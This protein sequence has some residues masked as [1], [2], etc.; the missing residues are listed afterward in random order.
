LPALRF[1]LPIAATSLLGL[2]IIA[3]ALASPAVSFDDAS[4]ESVPEVYNG[5]PVE[6]CAWPTVVAVTGGGLC[7]GTLI[8]PELVVYAAHCG[9]GQK[10]LRFSTSSGSGGFSVVGSCTT[11]PTY[12]GVTDVKEDWAFCRL[13]QPVNIPI[14]PAMHGCEMDLLEPGVE[15]ALIGFGQSNNGGAGTKRWALTPLSAISIE[16]NASSV[17][18]GA[19]DASICPGDSGGP[20]MLQ[21]EDGSWHAFGIAST[22]STT[23]GSKGDHSLI[24]GAIPWIESTSGIDVTPC[25]D[26]EGNWDPGP[27]CGDFH[28]AGATPYGDY[29]DGCT[30]AA[31]ISG[32]STSCGPARGTPIETTPPTVSIVSPESPLVVEP[33]TFVPFELVA[34]DGDGWGVTR[35]ALEIDGE[36]LEDFWDTQAP[37][38]FAGAKFAEGVYEVRGVAEDPWQNRGFS[39][40]VTIYAGV[41][42]PDDDDGGTG[43]DGDIGDVVMA[44]GDEGCACD[45]GPA[46]AGAAWL[47]ILMGLLPGSV[48]RRRTSPT[49]R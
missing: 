12:G 49:P 1:G 6:P 48:R 38:S 5:T 43:G 14:T 35:V 18:T 19:G 2:A 10:T 40:P 26:A 13:S 44:D 27:N 22:L 25:H 24:S 29:G 47:L 7:T 45:S 39:E 8:H 28:M 41:T 16:N 46:N 33:G 9:G 15:V 42:P 21:F 32:D 30:G 17:G 37:W 36:V 4:E 31:P 3:P 23:C 20:A 11:N 34:D